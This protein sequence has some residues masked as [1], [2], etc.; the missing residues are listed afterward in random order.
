MVYHS[1]FGNHLLYACQLWGQSN[2]ETQNQFPKTE[3]SPK[4]STKKNKKKTFKKRYE[5]AYPLYKNLKILM[6]HDLLRL[7]NCLFMRQL[8]QN[9]KLAAN[10]PGLGYTKVKYNGNTGSTRKNLVDTPFCRNF[11]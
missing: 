1:L 10:F 3:H 2:K 4:Q 6:L 11:T 7:N 8:E 5:S 9:K